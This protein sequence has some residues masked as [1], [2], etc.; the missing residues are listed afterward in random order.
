VAHQ[1]EGVGCCTWQV[2]RLAVGVGYC[3]WWAAH[4]VEGVERRKGTDTPLLPYQ[5]NRE[6][7]ERDANVGRQVAAEVC[8]LAKEWIVA[9]SHSVTGVV[10]NRDASSEAAPA[11]A[12]D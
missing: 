7:A 9:G 1:V 11:E 8:A 10:E 3:T 5:R 12:G 6:E 4:L 2:A